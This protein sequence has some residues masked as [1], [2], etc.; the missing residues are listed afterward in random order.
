MTEQVTLTE[1]FADGVLVRALSLQI[2]FWAHVILVELEKV[3]A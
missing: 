3:Q 2:Y 1:R